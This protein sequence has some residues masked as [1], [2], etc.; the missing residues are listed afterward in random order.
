MR[1]RRRTLA[2]AAGAALT[3]VTG[4]ILVPMLNAQAATTAI[5]AA[6]TAPTWA[7]GNTYTVGTQ[8]T[9]QG[10]T[11]QA[12]QTHTAYPGAGWTP[13]TTPALWKDLG[14]CTGGGGPTT[15]PPTTPSGVPSAPGNL[16]VTSTANTSIALAW[17]ASTG[18]VTGYR[19]YEGSTVR[20]TVTATSTTVSGL[21][22]G[23][24]HTYTVKAYNAQGES[25]ASNSATGTTTGGTTPPPSGAMGAAPYI[26]EGWGDPPNP[27]TVQSATGIKWFTMAFVL[28][29]GGCT[30]AWDGSRPLSGSADATA[31]SQ[32]RAGGGDVIPSFGGWQGNKLGPNCSTPQALAGAYQT[33]INAYG[34]KAIDIDIENTDEFEN[35]TVRNRIVDALKIVKQ[36]N[37]SLKVIVTFGTATTGPGYYAQQ[38]ISRAASTGAGIDIFT[39]MPFDFGGGANMYQ[40]TVSAS[41]G[42]KNMLKPAF[43]WDDATAYR[44]MGI[45]GMNGLSDQ[46][47]NT[48]PAQWQQIRDYAQNNHLARLA[49]WSVNRD[50]PCPGG[51][52]VSNC[53][54]IAQNNWQFTQI[55]ATFTG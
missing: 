34:L 32:I 39:I 40:S 10:H 21:T 35:D 13:S 47:E 49:F 44:H 51:G 53:S 20:A 15:P 37:P 42:L 54:G 18:T 24:T 6:C 50:R 25:G 45:S 17:N 52:V 12:L 46:Q 4:M 23:T 22:A 2:L 29:S 30:P 43:G 1:S 41:E 55:T 38:L 14:T 48:S 19:V 27:Q 7:E 26:Y 11:Y 33:V 9:Y 3:I 31:I 8:V 16:R 5:Q 28:S 36:N